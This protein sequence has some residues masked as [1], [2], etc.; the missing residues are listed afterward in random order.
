MAR[1]IIGRANYLINGS[2]AAVAAVCAY[3][4]LLGVKAKGGA[5]AKKPKGHFFRKK[6]I[7]GGLN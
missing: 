3:L 4:R 6:V 1:L 7:S 2:A 5:D